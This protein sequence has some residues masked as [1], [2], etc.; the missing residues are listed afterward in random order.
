MHCPVEHVA[1]PLGRFVRTRLGDPRSDRQPS[2]PGTIVNNPPREGDA[3]RPKPP[4]FLAAVAA[5]STDHAD[6]VEVD[7][8]DASRRQLG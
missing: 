6:F 5:A 3:F 1:A 2:V 8:M 7:Q 4:S